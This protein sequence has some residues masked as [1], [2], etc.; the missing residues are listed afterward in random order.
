VYGADI[1]I[2]GRDRRSRVVA[3][4]SDDLRELIARV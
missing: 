1:A 4:V 2:V 3:R